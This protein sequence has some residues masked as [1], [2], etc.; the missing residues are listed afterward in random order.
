MSAKLETYPNSKESRGLAYIQFEDVAHAEAAIEALNGKDFKGKQLE[1]FKLNKKDKKKADNPVEPKVA[2]KKNN[3]F[4]KNLPTG[5]NDDKLK[6]L[7]AEFGPIES[8]QIQKG[9][10][11]AD[12]DYGYVCFKDSAHAEAAMKAMDKKV[13]SEGKFLIVN[14]HIS[15]KENELAQGGRTIDPRTQN[16]TS[17]FNSN[18]YVKFIPIDVTEE[19]LRKQFSFGDDSSIVSLK[20]STSVKNYGDTEI[21]SQYAFILYNTVAN[22]QKAIQRFDGQYIFGTTKPIHVEMWVSKDEKD[23]ER[24]RRE[25]RTTKQVIQALMGIP[26]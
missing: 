24:K 7:F 12:K 3:L 17:T 14:Y 23:Q 13:I 22:A 16:M 26:N 2:P 25:D 19:E 10:D 20:L 4:V 8:A 18:I 6:A 9:P 1:I 15:K 11:G 5:T 21:K